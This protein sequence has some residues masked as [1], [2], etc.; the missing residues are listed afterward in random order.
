MG[1]V[2]EVLAVSGRLVDLLAEAM[3]AHADYLAGDVL[4]A[5]KEHPDEVLAQLCEW[6]VLREVEPKNKNTNGD[7]YWNVAR[8]EPAGTLRVFVARQ[9]E[10]TDGA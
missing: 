4:A 9:Q 3:P 2:K 5:L 7:D 6:G 8:V 1:G 10:A